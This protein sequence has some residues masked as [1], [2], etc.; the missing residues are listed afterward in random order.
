MQHKHKADEF[1][2]TP[3]VRVA[4]PEIEASVSFDGRDYISASRAAKITGYSQDYVGQLARGE[5]IPSRQIGSRWYVD[6][7]AIIEHKRHNDSL[8]GAVQ[9][10]SVGIQ[11]PVAQES[12]E[13]DAGANANAEPHFSYIQEDLSPIPAFEANQPEVAEEQVLIAEAA[14]KAA[15]YESHDAEKEISEYQ[16]PIRVMNNDVAPSSSFATE[17]IPEHRTSSN[18]RMTRIAIF[19]VA[20]LGIII[21]G[22][23][24]YW[25]RSQTIAIQQNAMLSTVNSGAINAIAPV[26]SATARVSDKLIAL[27]ENALS[28]ELEYKRDSR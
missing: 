19:F 2:P 25:Q 20:F 6:R 9:A 23:A 28:K 21:V 24:A 12:L 16:I 13:I 11:R 4:A 22:G 26:A 5:K 10:E 14:D 7:A 18:P 8:L 15:P 27:T 1:V 3:P 17:P